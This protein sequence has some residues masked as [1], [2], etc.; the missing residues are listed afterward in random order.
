MM[1]DTGADAHIRWAVFARSWALRPTNPNVLMRRCDRLEVTVRILAVLAVALLIPISAALGTGVYSTVA[2]QVE[3]EQR[4]RSQ[5]DAVIV[6]EPGRSGLHAA[7]AKVNWDH[8]GHRGEADVAVPPTAVPGDRVTLW[9]DEMG[10]RTGPPRHFGAA[11][12]SGVTVAI[13]VV[14]M[15]GLLAWGAAG[16]VSW[17]VSRWRG[18]QWDREWRALNGTTGNLI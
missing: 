4:S 6:G 1:T 17:I 15:T 11:A 8:N 7:A 14:V 3:I 2:A 16:S 12:T 13:A 18:R 9:V 10:R 5:V